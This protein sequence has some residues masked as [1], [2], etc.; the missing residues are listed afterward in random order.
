MVEK[1]ELMS[2]FSPRAELLALLAALK[3]DPDDDTPK[4]ALADWLEEQDYA[5]DRARGEF[6]RALVAIDRLSPGDPSRPVRWP[7]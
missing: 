4:L 6:L 2:D 1:G 5:A 3:A 7:D